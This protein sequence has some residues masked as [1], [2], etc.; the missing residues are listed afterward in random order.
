VLITLLFGRV[1]CSTLCPLGT[2]QD[3]VSRIASL[4]KS[5][6]QKRYKYARPHNIL[7]YSIMTVAVL[8]LFFG[9]TLPVALLDPYSNW[10]RVSSQILGKAEQII[11]N[12]L[13][14]IFPETIFYRSY[15]YFA[16]GAFIFAL[17]FITLVVILSAF[18]G[19]L[20]CNTICPVG[21][22]LGGLSKFSLFK[23]SINE[24]CNKCMAC[25][26]SCKS[27]C[28]DVKSGSVDESRCVA[29]LDC[30]QACKK[31]A[32]S[33]RLSIKRKPEKEVDQQGRRRA[34]L[35]IALL[36]GAVAAR[37]AKLGPVV[38]SK[39]KANAI[40]P[41]GA[42]SIEHLKNHCTTCH[43]CI[44]ACPNNII[45]P[46]ALEYGI[47]GLMLPVLHYRDQFC[48][49]ECNKCS[50]VCPNGALLP[51]TNDEKK[52]CQIGVANFALKNCVVYKDGTDC[53]ACD[54]HCP[55]NAITMVPY[56][57]TALYIPQLDKE[58]C[59]GCGACEY[60]CP[61]VPV[62][63]MI[64]KGNEQH[65]VAKVAAKEEQKS[66]KVDEFGF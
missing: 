18:R 48:T 13:S 65:R 23:P 66:V 41:P 58:V 56:G 25:I 47:E 42:Q 40:A 9:L 32:I 63:A 53:G 33:Y 39:T 27:Q 62:K 37:A 4:F 57:D 43:A 52:V 60:I 35:V 26:S 17:V 24:N 12:G 49:Y 46:A 1:Y 5:K 19:R 31:G 7:R 28:I 64:V 15:T 34:M 59:I 45:K 10:G 38:S 30:M 16:I 29:C 11:T 14:H 22:I 55:T 6:K 36:G 54:E 44:S 20:Y 8:P 21:S 51:L 3:I 2:F 50:Q 61:A